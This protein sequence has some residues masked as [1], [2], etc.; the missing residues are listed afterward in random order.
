MLRKN[1]RVHIMHKT[2]EQV[3]RAGQRKLKANDDNRLAETRVTYELWRYRAA[4]R[5]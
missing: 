4:M 3:R 1:E 2:V 5:A